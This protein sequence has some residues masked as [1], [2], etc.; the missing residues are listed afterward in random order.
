MKKHRFLTQV[1]N[2]NKATKKNNSLH[3]RQNRMSKVIKNHSSNLE[4]EKKRFVAR[5]WQTLDKYAVRLQFAVLFRDVKK[6]TSHRKLRIFFKKILPI[7][8]SYTSSVDCHL[9]IYYVQTE[10]K[11]LVRD[12]YISKSYIP[13]KPFQ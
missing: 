11:E 3:F 13:P 12:G 9:A 7:I 1:V 8:A 2:E 10:L 6:N 5:P 4:F